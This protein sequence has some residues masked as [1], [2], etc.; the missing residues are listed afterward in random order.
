MKTFGQILIIM[1]IICLL[2]SILL[3]TF[4]AWS[5]AI[6]ILGILGFILAA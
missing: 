5:I 4:G 2:Y 1:L 6:I 3:P